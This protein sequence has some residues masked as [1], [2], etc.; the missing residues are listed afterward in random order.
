MFAMFSVSVESPA[1]MK[2][3]FHH[4]PTT[5]PLLMLISA[6]ELINMLMYARGP[7]SQRAD[8]Q[9]HTFPEMSYGTNKMAPEASQLDG[10]TLLSVS[11]WQ[12]GHF[13]CWRPATAPAG[14]RRINHYSTQEKKW[15]RHYGEVSTWRK[16][17]H[18]KLIRVC[19]CVCV[20]TEFHD[21]TAEGTRA[22]V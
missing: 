22:S 20:Q 17:E 21:S 14:W 15:E 8:P 5:Q 11:V 9:W 7:C 3:W 12:G 1:S 18:N 4:A 2:S 10:N 16:L 19:V 6:V 13:G